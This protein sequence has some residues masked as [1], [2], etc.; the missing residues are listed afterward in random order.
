MP[1]GRKAGRR[2]PRPWPATITVS[3]NVE[4]LD[5]VAVAT[6]VVEAPLYS[7]NRTLWG[8]W[9]EK[10]RARATWGATVREALIRWLDDTAR[11]RAARGELARLAT[12]ADVIPAP[13][14]RYTLAITRYVRSRAALIADEDNL[15]FSAKHAID[16][17]VANGVLASDRSDALTRSITQVVRPGH[18][19]STEFLIAPWWRGGET[20]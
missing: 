10:H 17:L 15:V 9:T 1:G 19:P 14:G 13:P 12:S 6:L 7:P 18:P 3:R 16:A 2:A 11:S 20:R 5:A 8:H 4:A